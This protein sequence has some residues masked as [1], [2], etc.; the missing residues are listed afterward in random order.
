MTFPAIGMPVRPDFTASLSMTMRYFPDNDPANIRR[1]I[2]ELLDLWR[3]LIARA[4]ELNLGLMIGN[5]EHIYRWSGNLDD[6]F[7]WDHYKGH[8][9]QENARYSFD[10]IPLRP[11]KEDWFHFTYR[12]LQNII[13]IIR[14]VA[15]EQTG[16]PVQI[17][18][19][20]EPGPE[21]CESLFRYEWH[22]EIVSFMGGGHGVSIDYKGILHADKR[23]YG[24]YPHGIP[25]GEPFG[26]FLGKQ[27]ADFCRVMDIQN[28]S[29]SNGLGFGTY[30][31]NI[32]GRNFDGE[33]FGLTPYHE[34]ANDILEFWLMYKTE[35][36]KQRVSAQGSNWPVGVDVAAKGVP[37][38]DL[39]DRRLLDNPLGY[40]VSVFFDDSVGFAMASNMS[41]IAHTPNWDLSFYLHD[42]WYPQNPWEDFPYDHQA[43]DLYAP[44]S[45]GLVGAEGKLIAPNGFGTI[46]HDENADL[47][48]ITARSFMPH[49]ETALDNLPDQVG[50]LTWL[51][52]IRE[53]HS[54]MSEQP[55]RAN[56]IWF[57]DVFTA[58]AIDAGLPLNNVVSTEHF[59]RALAS[60][61]LDGTVLYTPASADMRA[62]WPQLARWIEQGGQV[63]FYGPLEGA[64]AELLTLLGLELAE[65]I[66][67]E[68]ALDWQRSDLDSLGALR[69]LLHNPVTSGGGIR[70]VQTPGTASEL[71]CSVSQGNVTRAYA[72]LARGAK[73]AW[74]RGSVSLEVAE[75]Q[76][77]R[78]HDRSRTFNGARIP[79]M[80]LGAMG[81][82]I[83]HLLRSP[84]QRDPQGFIS[85]YRNA[86]ILNGYK[87]DNTVGLALRF[88]GGAPVMTGDDTWIEGGFAHYAFDKSYRKEC[89]V[90][91]DQS[92]GSI[93]CR[94]TLNK[95]F[96][97]SEISIT[98]LEDATVTLYLPLDKIDGAYIRQPSRQT[99]AQDNAK[100]P[101]GQLNT[102]AIREG[103]KLVLRG[104]N[105]T[106]LV[107]W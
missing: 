69:Q 99:T 35:A 42:P 100:G 97:E 104:L 16:L 88:P 63:L 44:A 1:V 78:N 57:G 89:R 77:I 81:W 39:Y 43:F 40:T 50:P 92:S 58:K 95:E 8:N 48:P 22:P 54:M 103:D 93:S 83:R 28:I 67:G 107:R 101:V 84:Q 32:V 47:Q 94:K 13:K 80:L 52:P 105:G 65:P 29:F 75:G 25:E 30:P 90:L 10:P 72:V 33:R 71:V 18:T 61:V 7:E 11:F 15:A 36:P 70:E 55:E 24:A 79:C 3:P 46:V 23:R 6:E 38:L 68:L 60:G 64:Q 73:V 82:H 31:W 19:L 4:K 49:L 85:R 106:L 74:C 53:Y 51:Y 87:P 2:I 66:S 45:I 59:E 20:A 5:G 96:S 98:G 17:A 34:L 27:V 21:F 37:L 91:V 9:N 62:Y 56:A 102:P 41:R 26:R 12:D 76:W 14:K 86:F